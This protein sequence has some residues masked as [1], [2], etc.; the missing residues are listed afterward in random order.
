[1][2]TLSDPVVM[3]NQGWEK[4]RVNA[5]QKLENYLNTGNSQIMFTKKEYME[6]YTIVFN[7]ST[8]KQE[9]IQQQLYQKYTDS[10]NLYL[11]QNVLQELQKLHN[12]EL[13]EA[14]NTRW[15]NHEIMVK[16]MQRFFQY[17]DRFYVQI[18]S[19]TPLRDQGFKIFKGVIFQP[20]I[21]QITDAILENIRRER[22]GELVDV[23][24][25]KKTIEIYQFLSNEKLSQETLNCQKYLE[26]KILQQT[27]QFYQMQSQNLLSKASLSEILHITNKYYQEEI[28]RC[29]N[30][31]IFDIKDKLLKEF[32]QEMLLNHQ[33]GLLERESGIKYLLQQDKF[34]DLGLLYQ[35][36]QNH[37]ASLNPIANAF[38]DHIY[39]QG[40]NLV[41]KFDFSEDVK[42]HNKMKELL[43]S[44]QLVENLVSLLDKYLYMVKNCFQQ[45]A[46]F[47]RTRHSSFEAFMNKNRDTNR[48]NMSEVLA[49]YT[50]I[51]LRKG[52]IKIEEAKHEEYLEKIV[53][54]FTHLIDKDIFIEVFR[55]YLA[56]RLLI[57]K[58]QSI[59]LE[60]SMIS[61]VK[62]SCGPQFTKKLEGMLTDLSL[63]ADEQKK[64]EIHCSS[65]SQLQQNN[66]SFGITILTTSYWPTYKSFDI[67]IPREIDS[68]MK[69]FTQYYTS[70]HNH[71][72]LQWCY[73]L[74]SSTL[75]A[76]FQRTGKQYDFVVGTYQLCILMLFNYSQELRY[77]DI[78]QAMKFDDETCAKN[79][80]SLM[81][82]KCKL[83]EIRN[84]KSGGNFNEDDVIAVNELFTSQLKRV[85][86]PTPVLEEVFKKEIVQEDRS[87]AIEASIVRIMKSRKKLDHVNLVK[88]VLQTLQLFKP[89]PQV[90]KEK[91]EQLIEREYLERD[92]DDKSIYKYLA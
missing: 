79:L 28:Q 81:T 35:L 25:L 21:S 23:D 86:F 24:L 45:N 49:V 19:I 39:Q 38:K 55:S 62:L 53:K 4:I 69:N 33:Q 74:G 9:N 37:P 65:S 34:E 87:I 31:L 27:Q 58:S 63:A 11:S 67:Q 14:L 48:V 54:L 64:F 13:L 76:N 77:R 51:I 75:G 61:F 82:A 43:K 80:K 91:I 85:V 89:S 15:I 41:E 18:N 20:L 3:I 83:L 71:R 68:C 84:E 6:Y 8:L 56:K 12:D 7:L 29:E 1:M 5:I 32:Q 16:W 40:E 70:K 60:R 10:I 17:L 78:K 73:S 72:Q 42:D 47:E 92:P 57:E 36:Y 26:D 90:I 22:E 52:G 46:F 50:D 44:T 30:Y 2:A 88:E 66:I 59:D